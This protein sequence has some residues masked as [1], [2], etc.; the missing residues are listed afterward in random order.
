MRS[1]YLFKRHRLNGSCVPGAVLDPQAQQRGPRAG[2]QSSRSARA[3]GRKSQG[4]DLGTAERRQRRPR[5]RRV[6]IS[7][8]IRGQLVI[9]P[10]LIFQVIVPAGCLSLFEMSCYLKE[11]SVEEKAQCK[12]PNKLCALRT[13]KLLE[14]QCQSYN[15]TLMN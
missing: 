2:P 14:N 11:E 5:K 3:E 4:G 13:Y 9:L 10:K 6:R 8:L 1:G 15:P 12:Q 7:G